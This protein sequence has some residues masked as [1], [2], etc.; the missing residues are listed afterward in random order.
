MAQDISV[1]SMRDTEGEVGL[2]VA[3]MEKNV[4]N[5]PKDRCSVEKVWFRAATQLVCS[6]SRF[7]FSRLIATFLQTPNLAR[8]A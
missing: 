2:E 5:R 8:S 7:C 1:G 3:G 6:K 4:S